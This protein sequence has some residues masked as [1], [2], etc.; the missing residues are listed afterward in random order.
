[1]T[2]NRRSIFEPV[3]LVWDGETFVIPAS[4][5]MGA[6]AVV[7]DHVTLV[8]LSRATSQRSTL[9]IARVSMAWTAVLRYAGASVTE[10]EVYEG[11]L[12]DKAAQENVMSAVT[13]L[14]M[15]LLPPS[16]RAKQAEADGEG[17]SAPGEP[18]RRS[19]SAISS[20][21]KHTRRQS[22]GVS[23]RQSSGH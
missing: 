17:D 9:P 7:E 1:M 3:T 23:T 18:T 13:A 15:M 21:R 20:S 5:M 16:V 4:R 10:E 11:M 19:E 6:A 8:E 12:G 22:R 2:E 14:M